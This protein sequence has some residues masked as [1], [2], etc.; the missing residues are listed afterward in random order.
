VND[1]NRNGLAS[2]PP[3]NNFQ[4]EG[5]SSVG[6]E[7]LGSRRS[8]T[9]G[10][11]GAGERTLNLVGEVPVGKKGK[12][13]AVKEEEGVLGEEVDLGDAPLVDV[14]LEVPVLGAEVGKDEKGRELV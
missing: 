6:Y 9:Q 8:S 4:A 5:S 3:S 2:A 1:R 11:L 13:R 10:L 7:E 12:E 14:G